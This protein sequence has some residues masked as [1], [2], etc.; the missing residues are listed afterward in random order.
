MECLS[1]GSLHFNADRLTKAKISVRMNMKISM[2]LKELKSA[3]LVLLFV[4]LLLHQTRKLEKIL[5]LKEINYD[6]RNF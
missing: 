1:Q 3:K 4:D 2:W 5:T 6:L